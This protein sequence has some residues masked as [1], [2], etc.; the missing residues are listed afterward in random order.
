MMMSQS[1]HL[2]TSVNVIKKSLYRHAERLTPS[3]HAQRLGPLVLVKLIITVSYHITRLFTK[4]NV[5]PRLKSQC[6]EQPSLLRWYGR[7]EFLPVVIQF[8]TIGSIAF[9]ASM[10]FLGTV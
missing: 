5:S 2:L 10:G 7:S 8:L 3:R 4:D 9:I 6:R 1:E